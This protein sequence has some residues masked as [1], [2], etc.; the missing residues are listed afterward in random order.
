MRL[1]FTQFIL[2]ICFTFNAY[3]NE[4]VAQEIL[5]RRVS[6]VAD[7]VSLKVILKSIEA[8]TKVRFSYS[9]DAIDAK[10][11]ISVKMTDQKLGDFFEQIL[12]PVD[13]RY[14]VLDNKQILLY[15]QSLNANTAVSR[16]IT[17][18]QQLPVSGIIY[19]EKNE[20]LS[21][22]N[23]LEKGGTQGTTTNDKGEFRMNVQSGESILVISMVGFQ[24]QEVKATGG[25]M[26]II[27]RSTTQSLEDVVVVGYGTQKKVTNTGA[28]ASMAGKLLVQSPAANI[29]NSLVGR[30]PGLFAS[31][32]SGEPGNDQSTLRIR[33]VGTF[34]GS[35]EPLILVDGIQVDNYN[36]I[37]PNEI[38][39]I[40][41]LK[42][43][44]STA[45][46]GVR[47]ANGVLIITTKRGKT[48]PARVSYTFNNAINSFT[49][50]RSQMN[51]Y[52]YARSFNEAKKGD[53]FI[54]GSAYVPQFTDEEVE[55]FRTGSDPIFYPNTDWYKLMLKKSSS[56]QQHNLNI[57]GGT[58]KV[59]YAVSTGFF[60]QEGLY[61]NTNLAEDYDA[62]VKFK[63]FN[64]RS[65]LNFNIT[66]MF[67]AAI[68]ISSQTELRSGSAGNTQNIIENIAR[69]N[70]TLSP[71]IVDGKVIRLPQGGTPIEG[72]YQGGFQ[73]EY[74][75][76]LNGSVRL[77]HDLNFI[78]K[79]LGAHGI[80]AYQNFNS[81]RFLNTK[82]NGN[83]EIYRPLRLADNSIVYLP[84][85]QDAQYGFSE[86]IDKNRRQTAEFGFNY[87]RT[88]GDHNVTGLLLYNQ[89]KSIDPDFTFLIPSGY[90]SYV[91]R[92]TYAYKSRYLAEVNI[93]Y[94][95]T[96]NFAPGRRFGVFPAYSLGWV[97]S[98]E[99]FFPQNDILSFLKI[100]ASY[101]EV[102][103]DLIGTNFLSSDNRFLYRPT[104]WLIT[105]GSFFGQ[106]GS[107]YN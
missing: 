9:S 23:I 75:N 57:N 1:T 99:K 59:R 49:A 24:T 34:N 2:L 82:N 7:Q 94:Q 102:G 62:Q 17:I 14:S 104:A 11:K 28:Q 84:Q 38:E 53:A 97:A 25:G 22:V 105:G 98:E 65:N 16:T 8:Q 56:Q 93:A 32:A 71:G 60:N 100:R 107:N 47:G 36:N 40:T 12:L 50:I 78:T 79:G 21:G 77:E 13:I 4:S 19:N 85:N 43:A 52:D 101:G 41:I 86:T 39:N 42:D 45:V 29:S 67:R 37:D 10:R 6:L 72:L 26:A 64:F 103:S 87:N 69:A 30:L 76:Y 74:R 83:I 68:D 31:Q 33:G 80:V 15:Q 73:R 18:S 3:A 35:Q 46:Y 66:S 58:D 96:E 106:V 90:Q 92:T 54:A 51:S 63:R 88:F 48:G 27:L 44:S 81:Q 20:P 55:K 5:D 91:G 95:G 89:Q 70:P 61:N